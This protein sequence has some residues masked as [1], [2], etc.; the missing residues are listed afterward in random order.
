MN[1]DYNSDHGYAI[2]NL[3]D[4]NRYYLN[5]NIRMGKYIFNKYNIT[6]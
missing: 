2:I 4:Y 5:L 6:I 3:Y 1:S